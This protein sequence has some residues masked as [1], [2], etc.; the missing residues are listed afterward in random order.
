[1]F[2]WPEGRDLCLCTGA[3]TVYLCNLSL[4]HKSSFLEKWLG[5]CENSLCVSPHVYKDTAAAFLPAL[6]AEPTALSSTQDSFAPDNILSFHTEASIS[7]GN[8]ERCGAW[9][10]NQQSKVPYKVVNLDTRSWHN[11]FATVCISTSCGC[12][13]GP[14]FWV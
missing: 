11:A 13:V 1:M 7:A 6:P 4:W 3:T 14:T 5:L 12:C 2:I 8:R 10:F 9:Y